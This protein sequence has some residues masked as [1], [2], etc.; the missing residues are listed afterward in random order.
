[1]FSR[2]LRPVQKYGSSSR[3]GSTCCCGLV[4]RVGGRGCDVD[5]CFRGGVIP[6]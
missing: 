5:E 4:K 2:R 3:L 6:L 1:M